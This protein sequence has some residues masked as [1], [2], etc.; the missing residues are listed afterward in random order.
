MKNSSEENRK[1]LEM[2]TTSIVNKILHHPISMLKHQEE[3]GH[4]KLYTDMTRKIFHL[5]PEEEEE[6]VTHE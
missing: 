2:L 1:L 4:G 3:R 6:P 5:D